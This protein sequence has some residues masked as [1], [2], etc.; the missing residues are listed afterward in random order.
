MDDDTD[1][2]SSEKTASAKKIGKFEMQLEKIF[3][4]KKTFSIFRIN[5]LN[6]VQGNEPHTIKSENLMHT[7]KEFN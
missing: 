6:K 7:L 3:F 1:S 2:M 5:A 4:L